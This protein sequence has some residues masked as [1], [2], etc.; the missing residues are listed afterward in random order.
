ME[1]TALLAKTV[2][3]Q[4]V[5]AINTT[6]RHVRQLKDAKYAVVS[7]IQHSL[8]DPEKQIKRPPAAFSTEN[9]QKDQP[10][11]SSNNK[12]AAE[13]TINNQ[14]AATGYPLTVKTKPTL[15]DET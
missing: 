12:T 11:V 15:K 7:I 14:T 2:C 8:H 1:D 10:T 5:L 6:N 3:V 13:N 4:F 9:A